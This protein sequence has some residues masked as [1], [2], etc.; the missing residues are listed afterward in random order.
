[1][2]FIS[3][4]WTEELELNVIWT[5][6]LF[7]LG[8]LI[9]FFSLNFYKMQTSEMQWLILPTR[10]TFTFHVRRDWS[11]SID[12]P[13]EDNFSLSEWFALYV[14]KLPFSCFVVFWPLRRLEFL[15]NWHTDSNFT[16]GRTIG[17]IV[18]NT[19]YLD[20]YSNLQLNHLRFLVLLRQLCRP[21]PLLW[22]LLLLVP[23]FLQCSMVFPLVPGFQR[24]IWRMQESID[25]RENT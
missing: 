13:R 18:W 24:T 16:S 25:E 7:L 22:Q 9:V 15:R 20:P 17:T 19:F 21:Q 8:I 4:S 10:L 11:T 6:L 23:P 5:S 1:M 2:F 12:S 3:F 14:L